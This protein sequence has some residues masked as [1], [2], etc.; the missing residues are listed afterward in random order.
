[1]TRSPRLTLHSGPAQ[2][3]PDSRAQKRPCPSASAPVL[4]E[5]KDNISASDQGTM[6]PTAPGSRQLSAP[7]ISLKV[8]ANIVV[9][10]LTPFYK[11]GKFASKVGQVVGAALPWG[12]DTRVQWVCRSRELQGRS[13]LARGLLSPSLGLPCPWV[14]VTGCSRGRVRVC[15]LC[16]SSPCASRNCLKP[17]PATSHTR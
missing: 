15:A 3:N 7:S 8:A 6:N 5:V 4:A 2:E 10:C 17:S 11:E 9:K 12:W 14:T 13:R 1:M 16:S